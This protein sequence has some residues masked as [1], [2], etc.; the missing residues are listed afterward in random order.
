MAA[1]GT[2]YGLQ[3]THWVAAEG[4][5]VPLRSYLLLFVAYFVLWIVAPGQSSVRKGVTGRPLLS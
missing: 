3:A 4:C 2:G 5:A 1:V